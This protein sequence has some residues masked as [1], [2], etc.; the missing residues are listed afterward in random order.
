MILNP[1][2]A[3]KEILENSLDAGATNIDIKIQDHGLRSITVVD[4]G[5]GVKPEDFESL[6]AKHH[7]SKLAD[8]E[9]LDKVDTFG[10]RGEALSSL[11]AAATLTIITRHKGSKHHRVS[12]NFVVNFYNNFS[13]SMISLTERL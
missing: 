11:C 2:I 7:T 6:T 5:S 1:G 9:D 10:F 4:N 13:F 8:F 12:T 3:L